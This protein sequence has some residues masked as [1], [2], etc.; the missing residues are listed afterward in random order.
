MSVP[1]IQVKMAHAGVSSVQTHYLLNAATIL[2]IKNPICPMHFT[3][4]PTLEKCFYESKEK[5]NFEDASATCK[6]K[7]M[8]KCLVI[9]GML[10]QTVERTKQKTT[11]ITTTLS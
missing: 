11:L 5:L 3:Y 8:K 9:L 4:A 10:G 1:F 7:G 2:V 6:T